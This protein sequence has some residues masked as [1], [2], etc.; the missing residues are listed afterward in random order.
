MLS[1][2]PNSALH[3][4]T[5]DHFYTSKN[6][7]YNETDWNYNK[8]FF[9]VIK[10]MADQNVRDFTL[11]HKGNRN[12]LNMAY[13]VVTDMLERG[14]QDG[15]TMLR[16]EFYIEKFVNFWAIKSTMLGLA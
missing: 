4:Y 9:A 6:Q 16:E 1:D 15:I 5:S 2:Q 12:V 13:E 8:Q 14:D 7:L 3:L 10:E 11:I